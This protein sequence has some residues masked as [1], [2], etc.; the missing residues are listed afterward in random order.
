MAADHQ[1]VPAPAV[2]HAVGRRTFLGLE[3]DPCVGQRSAVER[4]RA[5]YAAEVLVGLTASGQQERRDD[6]R[7]NNRLRMFMERVPICAW[8]LSGTRWGGSCTATPECAAVPGVAVQ[9]PP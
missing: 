5:R 9:L 4:H 1:F 6:C 2:G 3:F 8:D 7:T